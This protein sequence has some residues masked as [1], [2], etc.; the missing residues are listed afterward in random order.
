MADPDLKYEVKKHSQMYYELLHAVI[1]KDKPAGVVFG[2]FM[3][4]ARWFWF[5]GVFTR[6][7]LWLLRRAGWHLITSK[8]EKTD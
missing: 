6:F 3:F 7:A 5:S 8:F 1:K 2:P 4:S